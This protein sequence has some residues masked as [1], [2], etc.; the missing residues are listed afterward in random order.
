ME[1]KIYK[2]GDKVPQ[3]GRYVCMVCGLVVEYLP[4]H[5][6]DGAVFDICT[7]C[8]AGTVDGPKKPHEEFW[9]LAT[10]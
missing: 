1:E 9:K 7:L 5:V 2:V 3:A 10:E 8:K 4:K 6:E